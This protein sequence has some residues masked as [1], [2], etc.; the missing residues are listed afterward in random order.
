[1]SFTPERFRVPW[2]GPRTPIDGLFLTGQDAV[3]HGVM[4]ALYSGLVTASVV[5][6]RNVLKDV[7]RRSSA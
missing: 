2:L 1:V 3:A 6:G 5:L 7:W 4:G